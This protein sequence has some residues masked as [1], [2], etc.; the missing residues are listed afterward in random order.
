MIHFSWDKD[1]AETNKSKHGI[2]FYEAKT[3]FDDD[4]GRVIF[5]PDHSVNEDRFVLMGMS[6]TL[7]ILIVCHCYR[8]NDDEIRIISARKANKK[9]TAQYRRLRK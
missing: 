8:C 7:K 6:C 4:F 9:E 5:D 2:S 1:K 3:T